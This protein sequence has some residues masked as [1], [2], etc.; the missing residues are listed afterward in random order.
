MSECPD[1]PS[2]HCFPIRIISHVVWLYDLFSLS[3]CGIELLLIE[4]NAV[5][6]YALLPK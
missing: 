5:I 1:A 2:D 4:R 6:P 3:L